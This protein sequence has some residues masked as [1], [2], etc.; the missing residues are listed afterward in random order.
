VFSGLFGKGKGG[1]KAGVGSVDSRMDPNRIDA[2]GLNAAVNAGVGDAGLDEIIAEVQN[3]NS[4]GRA[5]EGYR[6]LYYSHQHLAEEAMHEQKLPVARREV[7]KRYFE[8]IKP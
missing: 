6:K 3:V 2:T 8:S 1:L 7:V 5:S 4:S